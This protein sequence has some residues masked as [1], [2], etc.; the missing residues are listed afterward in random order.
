[1]FS[2]KVKPSSNKD[3]TGNFNSP[4][5]DEAASAEKKTYL[6][7]LELLKRLD[8]FTSLSESD[9]IKIVQ[10]SDDLVLKKDELLF[11]E[12]T[13]EKKMYVILS[14]QILIYK[15][16][17]SIKRI[18]VLEQGDYVG[19][20]AMVDGLPRS[21]STKAL[22]DT[23]LL[24]I[25]ESIFN[26]VIACNS[27]QLLAMMRIF[28]SRIR[29]DLQSM[30]NDMSRISNFT[31]DMRNCLVPLGIVEALLTEI[32]TDL[33][34]T[35]KKHAIRNGWSNVNKSHVTMLSVKN[36]LITM[37]DQSLACIKKVKQ[38]YVK[39]KLDIIPLIKET[40][41]ELSCHKVLK[42]KNVKFLLNGPVS[43]AFFN[44]LGIKRV[45]QNL[46]INAGYASKKNG[47]IEVHLKDLN[48]KILIS[49]KDF[50]C[51]IP[52]NIKPILLNESYTS[53]PDGNGFGLMS[54][55]EI[56][57][58]LHNGKIYFETAVE[59]GTTFYFTI[60]HQD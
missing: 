40:V 28:S 1:M 8:L 23:V 41:E 59:K 20:M 57:E 43:K 42:N 31:H 46:L 35:S 52:D 24:S 47:N 29:N 19:E 37:V 33:H 48:D 5:K 6:L 13:T 51:G 44:Y 55:K 3:I 36:N 25:N 53:R 14:G 50:G 54:C 49:V 22:C 9:L 32:S 12:G 27:R 18:I 21:A 26:K 60:S 4:R 11:E 45:L 2:D 34:G 15:G 39:A 7:K 58:E 38:N 17:R 56:I 30:E 16:R 10:T